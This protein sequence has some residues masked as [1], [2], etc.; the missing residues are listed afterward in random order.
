MPR[1]KILSKRNLRRATDGNNA[2][3]LKNAYVDAARLHF[4][5]MWATVLEKLDPIER[6]RV[7][8]MVEECA[9]DFAD[10]AEKGLQAGRRGET[11]EPYRM[12]ERFAEML[13]KAQS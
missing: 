13:K 5:K 3:K 4:Q 11:P 8:L 12:P 2:H 9:Q 10:Q 1:E 6:S 7:L